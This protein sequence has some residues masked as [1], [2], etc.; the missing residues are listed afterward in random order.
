MNPIHAG[1]RM[2]LV[3]FL[4]SV[5]V[6][7]GFIWATVALKLAGWSALGFFALAEVVLCFA[8]AGLVRRRK[9]DLRLLRCFGA[10]RSQVFAGVLAEAAFVGLLAAL[11]SS[12][13]VL[14]VFDL[15]IAFGAFAVLVGVGGAVIAALG[16]A[17][18]ASR[19]PP[20]GP[21]GNGKV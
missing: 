18:W 7:A 16:P 1:P 4:L 17:V 20:A 10:S 14:L 19:V 13:L 3:A 6:M 11:L 5:G 9:R 12:G 8:F 2:T 15:R 21:E